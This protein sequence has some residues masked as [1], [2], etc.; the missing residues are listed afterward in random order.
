MTMNE[1]PSDQGSLYQATF[2]AKGTRYYKARSAY[3][4]NSLKTSVSLKLR[5]QLN[6]KHDHNAVGIY[7]KCT[8][9]MLAHIPRE[10]AER[11]RHLIEADRIAWAKAARVKK[12]GEHVYFDC[13]VAI[14]NAV[15][16]SEAWKKVLT[17]PMH[18]GVYSIK[19]SLDGSQYIGESHNIRNRLF[20]H[21]KELDAG[22][23]HNPVLQDIFNDHGA[24]VFD[25]VVV[26]FEGDTSKRL[27][28]E[29][30]IIEQIRAAGTSVLLNC[31]PDGKKDKK[32][33]KNRA[34]N[35]NYRGYID[36]E[37]MKWMD[38]LDFINL[39]EN[40][41]TD[42]NATKPTNQKSFFQKLL[43]FFKS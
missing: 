23:H 38:E 12:V 22:C 26:E 17:I 7:L 41:D 18:P 37:T 29:T 20:Q 11:I 4:N 2:E 24:D 40:I 39:Q 36:A 5:H 10:H 30:E 35:S 31:T 25:F 13:Q 32:P 34:G 16:Q 28:R 42:S 15:Q 9:E 1:S 19:Y 6:N 8:G 33:F 27:F 43:S 14:E 3:D 21:L